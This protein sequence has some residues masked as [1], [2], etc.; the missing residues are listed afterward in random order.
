MNKA[1]EERV[2]LHKQA[3]DDEIKHRQFFFNLNS[4][5]SFTPPL[6]FS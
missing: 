1:M 6:F 3:K 4:V 5:P 2:K